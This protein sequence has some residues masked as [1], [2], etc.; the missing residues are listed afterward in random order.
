MSGAAA[1]PSCSVEVHGDDV[2]DGREHKENEERHMQDVPEREKPLV[3]GE[4]RRLV[5]G[6]KVAAQQLVYVA[7]AL[8]RDTPR[9][10]ALLAGGTHMPF[11][12][13]H[14]SGTLAARAQAEPEQ[15]KE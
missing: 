1:L 6:R 10:S 2:G 8:A 15:R 4:C 14:K 11:G 7:S 5:D 9:P 3:K 12:S 13:T